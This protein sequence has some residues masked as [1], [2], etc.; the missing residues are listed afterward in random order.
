LLQEAA[1]FL[2]THRVVF[3]ELWRRRED[4]L[5]ET[6]LLAII[7]AGRSRRPRPAGHA[8]RRP[9]RAFLAP[10]DLGD[11]LATLTAAPITPVPTPEADPTLQLN[12]TLRNRHD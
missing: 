2:Q 4:V 10:A 9:P 12:F 3:D 1:S 11:K 6:D 5:T 7:G 8:A